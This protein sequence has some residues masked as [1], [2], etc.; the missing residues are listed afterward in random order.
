MKYV[1]LVMEARTSSGYGLSP[2]YFRLMLDAE[3]ISKVGRLTQMCEKHDLASVD[4]YVDGEF[5]GGCD[6]ATPR[7]RVDKYGVGFVAW[8]NNGDEYSASGPPIEHI[9]W[10][11]DNTEPGDTTICTEDKWTTDDVIAAYAH[12]NGMEDETHTTE[13]LATPLTPDMLVRTRDTLYRVLTVFR[14]RDDEWFC[15]VERH[16]APPSPHTT[17]TKV[18]PVADIRHYTKAHRAQKIT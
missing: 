13:S 8:A 9:Q 10:I 5:V 18:I 17:V 7:M 4:V 6:T 11:L 1:E 2:D 15:W 3:I 12:N 16:N 14:G